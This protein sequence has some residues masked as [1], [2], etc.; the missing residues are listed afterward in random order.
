MIRYIISLTLMLL[1]VAGYAEQTKTEFNQEIKRKLLW[2]LKGMQNDM[3]QLDISVR[4]LKEDKVEI[5]RDLDRMRDWGIAQQKEK[6]EYYENAVK[7]DDQL[8][9][10]NSKLIE[11]E[12]IQIALQN[13][14][15]R[16]KNVMGYVVGALLLLIYLRFVKETYLTI[17][18][19]PYAPI[20]TFAGPA[21]VFGLGYI[22]VK[23][24][25]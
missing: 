13:K 12:K 25:F 1:S 2:E 11:N 19:G 15:T 6:F 22:L 14:Y 16:V 8:S 24:Y 9:S 5:Q 17:L 21:A 4:N 18:L 23:L 7:L 3:L 10:A 20:A